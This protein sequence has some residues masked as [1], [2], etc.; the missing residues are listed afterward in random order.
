VFT[1]DRWTIGRPG[2]GAGAEL[3]RSTDAPSEFDFSAKIVQTEANTS[4][5]PIHFAQVLETAGKLVAGGNVTLSFWAKRTSSFNTV[6]TPVIRGHSNPA[7]GSTY[8]SGG[9][10]SGA[11]PNFFTASGAGF[12]PTDSWQRYSFTFA[13]PAGTNALQPFFS[14]STSSSAPADFGVFITGVQLEAGSV[15]TPF[16]RHAPSLQG[17]LAACQRYYYKGGSGAVGRA[18]SATSARAMVQHPV[19]MRA[20]PTISYGGAFNMNEVNVAGRAVTGVSFGITA[21][22]AA[23]YLVLDASGGGMTSPNMVFILEQGNI[24]FEA[25]L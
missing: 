18:I 12:L 25:E 17:E 10:Y 14:M 24:N 8:Q 5:Q 3:S 4:T 6:L 1:A 21:S 15:A 9:T 2:A 16:K 22:P 11:N 19:V 13:I 23:S 20:T 7:A